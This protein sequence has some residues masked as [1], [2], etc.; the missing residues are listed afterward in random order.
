MKVISLIVL[1]TLSAVPDAA[2]SDDK[3]VIFYNTYGYMD[4]DEWVIPMRIYVMEARPRTERVTSRLLRRYRDLDPDEL[5]RFRSRLADIVADSEWRERVRFMFDGDG[6]ETEYYLTNDSGNRKRT[7][8]NGVKTGEI[9]ISVDKADSLM[10]AQGSENGWLTFRAV[11]QNH[12]GEGRV[13]LLEPE[14]ISVISDVDDTVKITEIPAGSRVVVRNTFIK[15]YAAAPRMADLYHDWEG[16]AFHY[17][18]GSPWQLYRPLSSFLWGDRAGFPEGTFH[19]KQVTKNLFSLTTW[20]GLRNFIT[21]EMITYDQKIEQISEIMKHFPGRQFIL[22]GD[23]GERD[24]EVYSE[25]RNKFPDQV[26][27]IIIRDVINDRN[28]R[29]E[30][31]EGM[32]IIPA[33]TIQPGVTSK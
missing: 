32:D 13:Q 1:L 4:G 2:A 33:P 5:F 25:I 6:T 8:L 17:V 24:P 9:R 26:A 29:P 11:S 23:S 14:G 10:A 30:R 20:S 27:Q 18:S 21:N 7:S 15:E 16:A 12:Q 19:M 22:V 31:L 3:Q 28:N